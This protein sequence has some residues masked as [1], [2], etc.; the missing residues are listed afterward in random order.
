MKSWC[1]KVTAPIDYDKT[2]NDPNECYH[3]Y[4][5][6]SFGICNLRRIPERIKLCYKCQIAS[7]ITL[8]DNEAKLNPD[9]KLVGTYKVFAK[10]LKQFKELRPWI[11]DK[12][13]ILKERYNNKYW[14]HEVYE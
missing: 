11:P 7:K 4:I 9:D 5:E 3:E 12:N 1:K 14:D 13:I 2:P 8:Y 6:I 10:Y